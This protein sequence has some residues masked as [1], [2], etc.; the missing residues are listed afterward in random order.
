[1][2]RRP[3][4]TKIENRTARL[5]L[6]V[7]KKPHHFTAIAPGIALAYRRCKGAGRWI[8]RCAD[9]KGGNWTK[10]F[11]IA[12]DFEEANGEHVL[13]FWQAQDKAKALARGTADSGKP[14]TIAEALD[15]YAANLEARGGLVANAE[16][17]RFHLPATLASKPVSLLTSKELER[18]RNGLAGTMKPASVN[19]YCRSLKAALNL[20]ARHDPRI[21]NTTAWKHGLASLPDAHVARNT[22]LSEPQ[23]LELVAAAYSEDPAFGLL[24]ETAATT[25]ARP[26]Q[27]AR[28]EVAD[29]Q[30][31]HG[32]GPRLLMPSSKKGRGRLHITRKPIPISS[33]LAAKLRV[34]A[35]ER[36]GSSPLLLRSDGN[37]W[38]AT[39]ADHRR[40]FE[41]AVARAGL[42]SKTTIYALRHSSITRQILAGTPL[43]VI[44][45]AHDTSTIMIERT[46]SAHISGHADA[47]LRK[48]LLDTAQPAT[49]NV[50]SLLAGRRT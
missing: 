4:S 48:G 18:F 37:P 25:G 19:R 16:R 41:R 35:G 49:G 10:G 46:Y 7:Q 29:L 50:V 42:N 6:P 1:M 27:L 34:A 21:N 2:A 17:V 26:S 32:D 36:V 28:L 24:V 45:D 23:I 40:P 14:I 5:K 39:S 30:T 13:T 20:A 12:D 43:R 8:V 44:A 31:D 33:S 3:R 15:A 47:A 38:S 11:A 9:G 22:V